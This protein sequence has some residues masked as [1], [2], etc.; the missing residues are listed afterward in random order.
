VTAG[1]LFL[2]ALR[3]RLPAELEAA[4]L[5]G[6][7]GLVLQNLFDFS[8]EYLACAVAASVMIGASVVPGRAVRERMELG[9][10]AGS[11]AFAALL[12]LVL[13]TQA[14]VDEERLETQAS[15]SVPSAVRS[16]ADALPR[17][18]RH[19]A[20]PWLY[21]G[22][23]SAFVR[24]RTA[25]PGQALVWVNRVLWLRPADAQA[26]LVAAH[27]LQRLDRPVQA[28]EEY[29]TYFERGGDASMWWD[30]GL[31]LAHGPR[32]LRAL[33]PPTEALRMVRL[34]A[35]NG[36]ADEALALLEDWGDGVD[37][38]PQAAQLLAIEA[39][40]MRLKGRLDD[41]EQVLERAE[42]LSVTNG[43]SGE[44]IAQRAKLLCAQGRWEA[45]RSLLKLRMEAHPE[46]VNVSLELAREQLESGEREAARRTV[47]AALS[48]PTNDLEKVQLLRVESEAFQRDGMSRHSIESLERAVHTAPQLGWL[49][50]ELAQRLEQGERFE[51][52]AAQVREGVA[53]SDP[54]ASPQTE[55]LDRLAAKA[56]DKAQHR[57]LDALDLVS[58]GG[59]APATP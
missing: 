5:C 21:L 6:V 46:D 39:G 56:K 53:H 44:V 7:A 38:F 3:S 12:A 24:D 47:R 27:A 29:R 26:H 20:D 16:L 8:L 9:F 57:S 41:A 18:D 14:T 49:H 13:P 50:F 34:L 35:G 10:L 1:V 28:L 55:W 17:I 19:P 33:I 11:A 15:A 58:N 42:H 25:N 30:E 32:Q 36:R 51:D 23:A 22:V 40:L 31:R 4:A 45:A 48:H 43:V 2:R 52:A 37:T 54:P 59:S